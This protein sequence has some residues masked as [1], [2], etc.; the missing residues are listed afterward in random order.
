MR[1][2]VTVGVVAAATMISIPSVLALTSG[3]DTESRRCSLQLGRL[4]SDH[5][6]VVA[7]DT[8]DAADPASVWGSVDCAQ[9]SRQQQ[10]AKGGDPH[11]RAGGAPQGDSAYR[12]LT[13]I[14][15]DDFYGERCEL[16]HNSN[17]P[18]E[19]TFARFDE[20]Q[21]RVT[22]ASL[23]FPKRFPLWQS[24]W[25]AVLQMKQTQPSANGGGAPILEIEVRQGRLTLF[26]SWKRL[27][28]TAVRRGAWIRMAIDGR[29]SQEPERGT[30]KIYVDV[31]GDGDATGP[32]EQSRVFSVRTLKRETEGDLP[33]DGIGPGQS[34]P[35][36]LRAGIYHDPSYDCPPRRPCVI[37]L[38]NVQVVDVRAAAGSFAEG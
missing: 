14:D 2:R 27:W 28:S 25:Q 24:M 4:D 11:R 33:S 15:G 7:S 6:A 31:D 20:G 12:R 5:C 18:S 9:T 1:A 23:R 35:S 37:H 32:R 21:R 3:G 22:F 19:P 8:A 29:Y 26:D 30:V 38:D 16:G 34:I 17:F 36:H 13:V 10:I